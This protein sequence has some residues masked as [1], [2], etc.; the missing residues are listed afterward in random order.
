MIKHN[1][2]LSKAERINKEQTN[3]EEFQQRYC[4]WTVNSKIVGGL[5][6]FLRTSN[7]ALIPNTFQA[8]YNSSVYVGFWINRNTYK[9]FNNMEKQKW[10]VDYKSEIRAKKKNKT[11]TLV[12]S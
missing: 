5:N 2:T 3:E 12:E 1:S 11:K 10:E 6:M 9:L 4:L 7:L 8:I